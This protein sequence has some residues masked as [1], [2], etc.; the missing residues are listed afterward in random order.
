MKEFSLEIEQDLLNQLQEVAKFE[1]CSVQEKIVDLIFRY[2][3]CFE[4]ANGEIETGAHCE[5]SC[6]LQ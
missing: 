3:D 1:G 6:F 2:I 4:K 5:K